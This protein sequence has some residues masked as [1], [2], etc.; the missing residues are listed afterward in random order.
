MRFGLC[1]SIDD[2]EKV[3]QVGFDYL[4][5]P[6]TKIADMSESEFREKKKRVN[7]TRIKVECFNILF[8]KTISLLDTSADWMLVQDYLHRAFERINQLEGNI[9]VFGSGKCRTCIPGVSFD[10]GHRRLVDIVRK[11]GEIA[12]EYGVTV[13]IEPLNTSECNTVNTIVEGA[14]LKATVN[15][16]NVGLL[17]DSY[18]MFRENEHMDNIARVGSLQHTHVATLEGRKFPIVSDSLL[19]DFFKALKGIGYQNRM[20][21][22]G[23]ADYFEKDAIQAL[24]LLKELDSMD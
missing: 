14:M 11:T 2:I 10:E 17:A 13:V 23:K 21:I 16:P 18:H 6:V 24:K 1:T 15:M 8:P 5:A 12:A 22:E 7:D 20:S 3:E 19:V 4:E 9:V